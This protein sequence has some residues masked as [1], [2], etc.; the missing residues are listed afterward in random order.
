MA[1]ASQLEQELGAQEHRREPAAGKGAEGLAWECYAQAL[2]QIASLPRGREYDLAKAAVET[3]KVSSKERA[4]SIQSLTEE[5]SSALRAMRTGAQRFDARPPI[6]CTQE[7]VED[8]PRLSATSCLTN[9]LTV[10]GVATIEAG[11]AEEG[12]TMV[13]EAMQVGRDFRRAPLI[14]TQVI[15]M[16]QMVPRSLEA[17]GEHQGLHRLAPPALA[18][19]DAGIAR[20]LRN[21]PKAP[22]F[23]G[24]LVLFMEAAKQASGTLRGELSRDFL[25]LAELSAG[26]ADQP[27][28]PLYSSLIELERRSPDGTILGHIGSTYASSVIT[29]RHS[30][31]RL[32][33]LHH[34]LRVAR[35]LEPMPFEDPFDEQLQATIDGD[36]LVLRIENPIEEKYPIVKRYRR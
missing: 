1:C 11:Q 26:C 15:G 25:A 34:A 7:G 6:D 16:D 5:L 21:T 29:H 3:A 10:A 20:M 13:L 33:M 28:L 30:I 19:L 32:Q 14:I 18:L 35:G 4:V 12:A 9:V 17:F 8:G 31:V 2:G 23:R 27:L 22:D 36:H 24:E